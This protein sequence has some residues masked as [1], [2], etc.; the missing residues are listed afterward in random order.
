[1]CRAFARPKRFSKRKVTGVVDHLNLLIPATSKDLES[2]D[3]QTQGF[4]V[5]LKARLGVSR[6]TRLPERR[7]VELFTKPVTL[8]RRRM[9]RLLQTSL[10]GCIE[11]CE[12]NISG[13]E[14][15]HR[16]FSFSRP[17]VRGPPQSLAS[18]PTVDPCGISCEFAVALFAF[19][20]AGSHRADDVGK[21]RRCGEVW[22]RFLGRLHKSFW[23]QLLAASRV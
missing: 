11:G 16:S 9:A 19:R 12:V 15:C 3:P 13:I 23:R 4:H 10:Q 21:S 1:M 22:P 7:I 14:P 17:S 6:R 8:H 20:D 2:C 18:A 5:D